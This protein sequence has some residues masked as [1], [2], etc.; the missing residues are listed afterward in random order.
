MTSKVTLIAALADNNCIGKDNTIPWYVP[1]DFAFFKQYTLGKPV[2]MGRK[3]WESLPRKPL[4]G[5]ANYVVSRQK[6]LI[7]DGAITVNSVAQAINQL[8]GCDEIIIMGGAQIYIQALPLATDLRLTRIHVS[9]NGD[10]FFPHI[11]ADEWQM[12][13]STNHRSSNHATSYDFQHFIRR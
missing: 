8:A 1:E 6:N 13:S 4:P 10:T 11:A 7:I 12:I 3:T 5:R 9:V 2:V